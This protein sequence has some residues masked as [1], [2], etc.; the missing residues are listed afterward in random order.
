MEYGFR[1]KVCIAGRQKTDKRDRFTYLSGKV[2][3][4][5]ALIGLIFRF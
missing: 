4:R 2:K 5:Q 1:S 3:M